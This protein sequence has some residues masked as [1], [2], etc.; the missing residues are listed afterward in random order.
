M[1]TFKK[2]VSVLLLFCIFTVACAP[3][4]ATPTFNPTVT[5]ALPT[6]TFEPTPAP[7]PSDPSVLTTIA[8][9]YSYKVGAFTSSMLFLS[10]GSYQGPS[11]GLFGVT[12]DQ[13]SFADGFSC[14]SQPG[15][16]KWTLQETSL[17]FI[18]VHDDC[19]NRVDFFGK[20]VFE[21]TLENKASA[22]VFWA[23]S[24]TLNRVATDPQGNIYAQV[25]Y[26]PPGAR[27]STASYFSEFDTN[28][29]PLGDWLNG[30]GYPTGFAMDAQGNIY[31]ADFG[32]SAIHKFDFNKKPVLSWTVD[33]DNI[34]PAGIGIDAQGN[35]YVALHRIHDH[36]IEKYDPQGKLLGTWAK[37]VS[38]G[39]EVIAGDY[40]GPED[41][42]VDGNGNSYLLDPDNNTVIKYD[43][44]GNF[45]HTF[46]DVFGI[47]V[48]AQGNFYTTDEDQNILKFD[49]SGIQIGKWSLPIQGR[50]AAVDKDGFILIIGNSILAKIKLPG[51]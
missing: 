23:I 7:P 39:G 5:I 24:L 13:I 33:S 48:D 15:T 20:T 25:D 37:P 42:A 18:V 29:K 21:K 10:D 26:S 50:V 6:A 17:T 27:A 44:N 4:E 38:A 36:Y 32:N 16:Y 43:P 47:A 12:S 41:I 9:V 51:Q 28:G 35:V 2:R 46:T 1:K 49:S 31:V 8:G 45:L 19:Q 30:V 22:S 14:T 40:S 34:G 3:A 11:A